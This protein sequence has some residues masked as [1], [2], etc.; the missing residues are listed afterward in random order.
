MAGL[1]LIADA[2]ACAAA[3][4]DL[5]DVALAWLET[6]PAMLQVRAKHTPS[7]QVL[8]WLEALREP[9]RTAGVALIANDRPDLAVLAGCDGVHLGQRDVPLDR[10]RELAPGLRFGLSTHTLEQ[11]AGAL[12]QRPDYVAYGPVFPTA[13][14]E[15]PDRCVG[16]E[17]LAAAH[18]LCRQASIPLVAIGGI[19]ASRA[20][21]VAP[22]CE[23]V[24]VISAGMASRLEGLSAQVEGLRRALAPRPPA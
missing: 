15:N 24:A 3:G 11:L 19:E 2:D 5:V 1:Y 6:R 14:K 23:F 22:H 4:L 16:I 18:Q 21:E 20:A 13:S 9:A 10:A 12:R 7:A 17:G 8:S